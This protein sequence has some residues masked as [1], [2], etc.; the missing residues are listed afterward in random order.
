ML[1]S[2]KNILIQLANIGKKK[3]DANYYPLLVSDNGINKIYK[4]EDGYWFCGNTYDKKIKFFNNGSVL[5]PRLTELL[6]D[7]DLLLDEKIKLLYIDTYMTKSEDFFK[8]IL[9]L[10][11]NMKYNIDE[12]S[13]E[14]I[15]EKKAL[16]LPIR[17][18]FD[19]E[20]KTII[21][22]FN[23]EILCKIGII[24]YEVKIKFYM[25]IPDVDKKI[26][27]DIIVNFYKHLNA[28]LKDK[29]N[30]LIK[31]IFDYE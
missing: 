20:T 29:Q 13:S 1:N 9:F 27:E 11:L 16:F 18:V 10:I 12:L 28:A 8:A 2:F 5:I 21:L 23:D 3:T 17:F 15:S 22:T 24:D 14:L 7:Y 31:K 26:T 6:T 30:N 25:N 19:V 4:I